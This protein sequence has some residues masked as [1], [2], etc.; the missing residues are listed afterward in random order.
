MHVAPTDDQLETELVQGV[1][2][3]G[4][5]LGRRSFLQFGETVA[6]RPEQL[7]QPLLGLVRLAD[8]DDGSRR[9]ARFR[10]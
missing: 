5:A 1:E 3:Q 7:R 6:V 8:G 4:Q 2:Q 9:R 10:S